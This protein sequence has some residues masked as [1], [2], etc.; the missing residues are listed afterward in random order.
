M[1]KV[2]D[3]GRERVLRGDMGGCVWSCEGVRV[4]I[5]VGP[6]EEV[7]EFFLVLLV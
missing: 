7:I 6:G 4:F 2:W 1:K 3:W 5:V